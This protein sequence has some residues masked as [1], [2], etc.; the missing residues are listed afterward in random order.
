VLSGTPIT[1]AKVG[2][3][4]SFQPQAKD[5]EGHSITWSVRGKPSWAVFSTAG[6]LSGTPTTA[7]TYSGVA[8]SASDGTN[9][10]STATFTITVTAAGGT[11]NTAPTISGT[12]SASVVAG[13]AY[14]F[15]P[16]AADA[17]KD[18]LSFTVT[19][20]PTWATLSPTTGKLSGTPTAS[21]VGTTS[22]IV[23]KVS[24]GKTSTS[25]KAFSITVAASGGG[26][27]TGAATVS[28]SPPTTNNNGTALTNLAGYRISYGKTAS[29]LTTTVTVSNP[30]VTNYVIENL[31]A[32]TWYFG[33][34]SYTSAGTE[35]AL[36]NIASKTVK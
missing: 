5:P 24:D 35:S 25:L 30:G 14:S 19:N 31:A 1:T 18:P 13:S 16:T 26:T 4:Y 28:W 10:V 34:K 12:P 29:T 23:I 3:A 7:G 32:G 15:T 33:V 2:T 20:K 27:V 6:K 22:N 17:N 21:N 36:S 9:T 11:T 8:I